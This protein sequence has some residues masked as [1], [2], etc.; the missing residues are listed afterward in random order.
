VVSVKDRHNDQ[1]TNKQ[2]RETI[3]IQFDSYSKLIASINSYL[4]FGGD[5]L[6]ESSVKPVNSS[7]Q[8]SSFWTK[9][10][11]RSNIT[12]RITQLS[13]SAA[14]YATPNTTNSY[15]KDKAWS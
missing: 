3:E 2:R 1:A 4:M 13:G 14:N 5:M 15:P 8:L 7:I 10:K 9:I 6:S 11:A 12:R